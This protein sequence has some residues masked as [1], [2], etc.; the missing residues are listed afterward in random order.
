MFTCPECRREGLERRDFCWCGA[1]V[2]LLSALEVALDA[3]YNA[4]MAA[5]QAKDYARAL[6]WFSACAVAR[7]ADAAVLTILAK[8]W[9]RLG[10]PAPALRSLDSAAEL[11]PETLVRSALR[12]LAQARERGAEEQLAVTSTALQ[13][14]TTQPSD[15]GQTPRKST[16]EQL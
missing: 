13:P 8:L 4:G 3:W 10:H 2:S 9:L 16:T 7:P 6:E 14:E 1:D 11:E 15:L 12:T 5:V